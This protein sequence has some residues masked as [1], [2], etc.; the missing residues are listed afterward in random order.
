MFRRC[1]W[2]DIKMASMPFRG[3]VNLAGRRIVLVNL[4]RAMVHSPAW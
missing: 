1:G 2:G 4:I 3:W